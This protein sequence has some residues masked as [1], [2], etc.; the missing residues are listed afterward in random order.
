VIF[1][2]EGHLDMAA[3]HA[4]QNKL[5]SWPHGSKGKRKESMYT[6][7]SRPMGGLRSQLCKLTR[8]NPWSK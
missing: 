6:P 3:L 2:P 8:S 5:G 1:S 7:I 4:L